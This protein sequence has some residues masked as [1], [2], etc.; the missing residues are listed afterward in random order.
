MG[1]FDFLK[2]KNKGIDE[3]KFLSNQFQ[4]EICA[5]ALWKLKENNSNPYIAIKELKKVGLSDEQIDYVLEKTKKIIEPEQTFNIQNTDFG[6]S[7][8]L[9][10][11]YFA[12][13]FTLPSS[14]NRGTA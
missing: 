11:Q 8:D 2:K 12:K 7:D 6:I 9:L 14:Q 1:I 5:L 10:D 13:N 4:N 3:N